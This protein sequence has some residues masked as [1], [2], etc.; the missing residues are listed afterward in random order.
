MRVPVAVNLKSRDGTTTKDAKIVNAF[1]EPDGDV[2]RMRSRPG[3]SDLGLVR[4]GT[5]QGAYYFNGQIITVHAN[6]AD[7]STLPLSNTSIG[8][9]REGGRSWCGRILRIVWASNTSTALTVLA[10]T[11]HGLRVM[12]FVHH[13]RGGHADLQRHIHGDW[14]AVR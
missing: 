3:N 1:V 7:R 6:N 11:P 14:R 10:L 13:G 8:S 12:R 4:A 2:I 5:A 9:L